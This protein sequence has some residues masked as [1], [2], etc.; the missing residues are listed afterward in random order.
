MATRPRISSQQY[1][2]VNKHMI[3]SIQAGI[4]QH[5]VHLYPTSCSFLAFIIFTFSLQTR[6]RDN[7]TQ[8]CG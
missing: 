5:A 3:E 2:D 7:Q 6:E 4:T 8:Q 1:P